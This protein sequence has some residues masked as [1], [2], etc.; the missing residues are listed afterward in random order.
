MFPPTD[1]HGDIVAVYMVQYLAD[2][3]FLSRRQGKRFN[4]RA[5]ATVQTADIADL[6]KH[7]RVSAKCISARRHHSSTL[8]E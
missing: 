4:G 1:H 5:K 6:R 3:S 2:F 7:H 8:R